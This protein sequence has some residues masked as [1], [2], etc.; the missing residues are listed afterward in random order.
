MNYI[1][2]LTYITKEP[3]WLKKV[4]IGSIV[5]AFPF[6]GGAASNGYQM[7]VLRNLV[8]RQ[9]NVLPEWQNMGKLFNDGLKLLL[10]IYTLYVPAVFLSGLSWLV[11]IVRFVGYI[12]G[13]RGDYS[14]EL[15]ILGILLTYFFVP[16][17][18]SLLLPLSFIFVPAMMRQCA[19]TNSY[20]SVFNFSAHLRF[21]LKNLGNYVLAF[22]IIEAI[23]LI[24]LPFTQ[25]FDEIPIP[26]I[27]IGW[28]LFALVRFWMRLS[29][30]NYLAQIELGNQSFS[31][32][33]QPKYNNIKPQHLPDSTQPAKEMRFK[34]CLVCQ[35]IYSNAEQNFCLNEGSVLEYL[36][37]VSHSIKILLTKY[38][39]IA[40]FSE[41]MARVNLN[42]KYGLIDKIGTEIFPPQYKSIHFSDGL[43]Y[44]K[45]NNDKCG[46]ISKPGH[47]IIPFKYEYIRPFAEG[48]AAVKINSK[49]G[50][51]DKTG[52]EVI[53][54][55]YDSVGSFAGGSAIVKINNRSFYIDKNGTGHFKS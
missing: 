16:L 3:K 44:I 38:D 19:I 32:L 29:W 25:I 22:V 52:N 6:I 9:P 20:I 15:S 37:D 23:R 50:F 4:F 10:A 51:I 17:F 39:S 30:A 47:T 53:P 33:A 5:T 45:L 26:G 14:T 48:L 55:K 46:A 43:V 36:D 41:D 31:N 1:E 2:G 34:I 12:T 18:V 24:A 49:W 8:N 13:S 35:N 21:I 42:G 7:Q 40:P 28:F 11:A 27:I 54:P